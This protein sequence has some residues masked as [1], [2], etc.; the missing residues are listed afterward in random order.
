MRPYWG[1]AGITRVSE[2]TGLDR[3]GIPVAQ[4]IRPDAVVLSVDSGKG[5][6]PIAAK[7][8]AMME[9]FER[10]VGET[11]NL[12]VIYSSEN[13]LPMC[14]SRFPLNNGAVYRKDL[15]LNWTCAS[16]ITSNAKW[17]VPLSCVKMVSQH[18]TENFLSACFSST[19]NGLSSGNTLSEAVCGGL[20]EVVERDQITRFMVNKN[21]GKKVCMENITNETLGSLVEKIKS[22]DV[23]PLLF[24]CTDD[25]GIPTYM[26]FLYDKERGNSIYRGYATHLDP[27]VAQCRALCE[28][29][30]GRVVW[31]SGSRDDIGHEKF[32]ETRKSDTPDQLAGILGLRASTISDDREDLSNNDFDSDINEILSRFRSL[33]LPE[34]IF[35]EFNH[36]YPCHVVRILA[37]TLE[38]YYHKNVKKGS[39]TN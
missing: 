17:L 6:T 38:G 27:R 36:P 15:R 12:D 22:S 28:A 2:I 9:G 8:S 26:G 35:V 25:F 19:S 37:P 34:P 39:R 21:L 14:E 18:Y 10:H 23:T 11:C 24:D 5:A 3:I 30:Q 32:I 20:Y 7:V 1:Q 13:A 29:V 4:C 33:C 16:G 31:M